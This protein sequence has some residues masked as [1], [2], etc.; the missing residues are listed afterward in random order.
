MVAL[1]DIKCPVFLSFFPHK[2]SKLPG[3]WKKHSGGEA[4]VW[5][6][7]GSYQCSWELSSQQYLPQ[8]TCSRVS[9]MCHRR[10]ETKSISGPSY[11]SEK[12]Y[13]NDKNCGVQERLILVQYE[14]GVCKVQPMNQIQPATCFMNK[15]LLEHSHTYS[16]IF[17][18][19]CFTLQQQSWVV[20]TVWLI[21]LVW[22]VKAIDGRPW[23]SVARISN[24]LKV[25]N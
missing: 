16:F 4:E 22:L 7:V 15:V 6:Q 8:E 20:A 25:Y 1:G 21:L 13:R 19:G 3:H 14:T 23:N 12:H 10:L 9:I 5:D 11:S 18:Y 17:Y 2:L 24:S